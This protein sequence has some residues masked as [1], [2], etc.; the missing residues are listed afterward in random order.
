MTLYAGRPVR[1]GD[2]DTPALIERNEIVSLAFSRGNL[3]IIAEGRAL[4]RGGLNDLVRVMNLESRIPVTGRVTA[5]GLV[6]VGR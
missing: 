2:L 1:V 5:P 4:S 3:S 6:E